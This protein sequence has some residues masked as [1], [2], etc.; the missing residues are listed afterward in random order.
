MRVFG[1]ASNLKA[2]EI[3]VENLFDFEARRGPALDPSEPDPVSNQDVVQ[4]GMK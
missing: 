2:D 3:G 1:H 4:R